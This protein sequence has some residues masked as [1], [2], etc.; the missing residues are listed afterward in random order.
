MARHHDDD[1]DVVIIEK[2]GS[3]IAPFF[4]GLAVGAGIALL[5]APM[6]GAEL[7][8]EIRNRGMRLKDMAEEKADE[9]EDLIS[10]KYQ[11]ARDKIEDGVDSVK[12]K[13]RDGKQFGSEV[14]EAGRAASLSA[15]EELERRLAEARES[16]RSP[17]SSGDEEPVA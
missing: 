10:D 6:S 7:R 9:L 13:V 14:A 17:R 5:F 1:E 16:R 2:G 12:R 11:R 15:R 3:S 4:W 8:S